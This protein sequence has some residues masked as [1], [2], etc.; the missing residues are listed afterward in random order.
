MCNLPVVVTFGLRHFGKPEEETDH[1][2]TGTFGWRVATRKTGMTTAQTAT[3]NSDTAVT[4]VN[5]RDFRTN[6][7]ITN[8]TLTQIERGEH[9]F[10]GATRTVDM[11]E[12]PFDGAARQTKSIVWLTP[13]KMRR[14]EDDDSQDK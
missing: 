2:G 14:S 9:D 8:P 6:T 13:E 12:A 5:L 7:V 1:T 10:R 11:S 3:T 4:T